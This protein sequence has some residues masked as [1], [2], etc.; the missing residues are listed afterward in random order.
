MT[1]ALAAIIHQ[2]ICDPDFSAVLQNCSP[3]LQPAA[4]ADCSEHAALHSAFSV[5]PNPGFYLPNFF[6]HSQ[7]QLVSGACINIRAH[8]SDYKFQNWHET[9]V[10][11]LFVFCCCFFSGLLPVLQPLKT[12]Q[13][14][15]IRADGEYSRSRWDV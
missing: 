6:K 9:L 14:H 5:I 10:F 8:V 15:G 13:T 3:T 7:D 11:C 1:E 4:A 2:M 12:W